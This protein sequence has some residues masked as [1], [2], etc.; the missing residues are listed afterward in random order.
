[1]SIVPDT[2]IAKIKAMPKTLLNPRARSKQHDKYLAK[3][4]DV[5]GP[6]G[7]KFHLYTRQSTLDPDDFSTGLI[8][9]RSGDDVTLARYNGASHVHRNA[10]EG[11]KLS[12][13]CHI[14]ELTERY[15]SVGKKG[16]S[17]AVATT[18]YGNLDQAL[19]LLLKD[20]NILKPSR[21]IVGDDPDPGLL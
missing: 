1:M 14:H 5:E 8:W 16:E 2:D 12:F 9:L 20:W 4:Y 7:E 6:N 10:I 11:D 13:V 17:Y 21:K 19:A 3:G 18:Q 15:Q